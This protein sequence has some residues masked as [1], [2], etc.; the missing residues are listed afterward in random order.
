MREP[1][2][3]LSP[4]RALHPPLFRQAGAVEA[5]PSEDGVEPTRGARV[6]DESVCLVVVAQAAAVQVGRANGAVFVVHGHHLGVVEAS[7]EQV[8]VC[9]SLHQFVGEVE[10][11]VGRERHIADGGYQ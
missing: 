3:N 4:F 2:Y 10:G 1:S 9:P 6:E 11:R 5:I 8:D 7:V